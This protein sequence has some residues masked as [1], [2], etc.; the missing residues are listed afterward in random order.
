MLVVLRAI[1]YL[2]V[3]ASGTE[4]REHIEHQTSEDMPAAKVYVALSRLENQGLVTARDEN[5]WPAGR[6]GRPRRIYS[7]T[8]SGLR[9][10]RAGAK[11]YGYPV[12]SSEEADA[13]GKETSKP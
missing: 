5:E 3:R 13:A 10:L 6:R 2:G 8:A 11:L 12:S 4:I 1:P 9:A 7:L